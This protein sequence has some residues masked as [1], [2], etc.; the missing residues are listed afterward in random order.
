MKIAITFILCVCSISIILGQNS[1]TAITI[2]IGDEYQGGI[3]FYVDDSGQHGLIA[4]PKD[5]T[6]D[7]IKWGR[8]GETGA[9][10]PTDGQSNTEKIVS[11]YKLKGKGLEKSAAHLC[12]DLSLGGYTDW[13]LPAINELVQLHKE[14][15]IVG[16]FLVGDYCSSTEQDNLNAYSVHFKPNKRVSFFYN[17][18][19]EDYF[20]RCIRKF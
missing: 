14:N 8:N 1:D 16:N 5:Q 12:D 15:L 13:Y 18:N 19:D 3:V 17:K 6:T 7:K 10:S 11:Y 20:V 9:L 2:K 4:A